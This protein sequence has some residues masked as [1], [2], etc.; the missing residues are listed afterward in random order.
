[1][2]LSF[3]V[4]FLMFTSLTVWGCKTSTDS[5]TQEAMNATL[6]C[7]V[8]IV[9]GG[10]GGLH[11]AFRL[12]PVLGDKV[13]LFEKEERLG[14]RIYDIT[15][16]PIN[17]N[18]PYI[19][20]GGRRVMVGQDVVFNL[21]K[22]LG[23][24]LQKPETGADIIFARGKYA[25]QKDDFLKLYPGLTYDAKKPDAETQLLTKLLES[26]ERKNI[27]KYPNFRSYVEKVVGK[28]GYQYLHDMSRFRG[29][30]EYDLS[31]QGYMD[32]LEEEMNVCCQ[33]FYPIGGMSAF[34]RGLEAK[35]RA[36]G[37]RI[38]MG[39]PVTSI[40]KGKDSYLITT[41]KREA[42]AKKVVISVPPL[43][44]QKVRGSIAE[45]I[46][47]RQEFKDLIGIR[48]TVISQW[49]DK[50][51]WKNIRTKDG[52]DIWRAYTTGHCINYLEIPPEQ[53]AVQQT[54][55]R[56]VYND[57]RECAEM[58]ASLADKPEEL[59]AKLHEGLA[60]VFA[61][62][63]VTNPVAIPE[64]VQTTFW[65]WKDGW[66]MV[67]AGSQYSNADIFNWAV[68]PLPGEDVGLVSEGYN[69]QRS[70]WT[71]GAYKSSIH[72]LNKK[73]GMS[74]PGLSPVKNP[75]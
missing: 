4:K 19:G 11:T 21:A 62:N 42:F 23:I 49:F 6:D 27:G 20:T 75:K 25:T 24:E 68:E 39:E 57:Q 51:W 56:T 32:F 18:G 67:K 36:Y 17:T 16:S 14:G 2:L 72:L 9:G 1:M 40:D 31:A 7:E 41:G 33:T 30:F 44:F 66:Y 37:V 13:C 65:D 53:Y 12:G 46:K 5:T 59:K 60:H 3:R 64:A 69:P 28:V 61:E 63:N 35:S 71:D 52:Q 22:E 45:K 48:V 70:A 73:Y 50:P 47:A 55:I 8:V 58:W 26:P 15:K 43:A 34:V 29:D 54:V 74:L 10:V 38:F